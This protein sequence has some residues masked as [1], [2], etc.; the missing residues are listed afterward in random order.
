C[1]H[2]SVVARR[3]G[4]CPELRLVVGA[5]GN[6]IGMEPSLEAAL[7][8]IFGGRVQRD[9]TVARPAERGPAAPGPG[10][11]SAITAVIQRA[12]EAWQKGQ[13]ALRKGDWAVYGQEQRRV[14]EALR[15]LQGRR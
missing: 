13:D 6:Q 4:A 3:G 8:R 11:D 2:L 9:E 7:A 14:E 1:L 10:L 5:Y 15:E 12:W